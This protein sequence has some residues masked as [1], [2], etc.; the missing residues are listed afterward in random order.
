MTNLED[1]KRIYTE[2]NIPF[3]VNGDCLSIT[4]NHTGV[5]TIGGYNG[6]I[7]EQ[8]F[9]KEGVLEKIEIWE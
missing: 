2:A 5:K 8:Y 1:L 6:F 7:V 4:N 3:T 9:T